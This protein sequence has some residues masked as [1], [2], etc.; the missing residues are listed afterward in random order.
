[1]SD[2]ILRITH[3]EGAMIA[4]W[5]ALINP[6]LAQQPGRRSEA[7]AMREL[8]LILIVAFLVIVDFSRYHGRYTGEATDFVRHYAGKII[9]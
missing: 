7:G 3:F 4:R 9:R 5:G 2:P 8:M 6:T 1:M